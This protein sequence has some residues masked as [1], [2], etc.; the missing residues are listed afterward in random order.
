MKN[1]PKIFLLNSRKM[2]LVK[3][4]DS[5]IRRIEDFKLPANILETLKTDTMMAKK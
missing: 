1:A 3:I 2:I 4:G 5:Y